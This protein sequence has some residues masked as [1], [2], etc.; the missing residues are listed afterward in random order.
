MPVV[1]GVM[2]WLSTKT[3]LMMLAC[4]SL[5]GSKLALAPLAV[6]ENTVIN[7]A[8]GNNTVPT[9]APVV[10][11]TIGN[12]SINN[13]KSQKLKVTLS[14][15]SSGTPP[16]LLVGSALNHRKALALPPP[17]AST[18]HQIMVCT[19]ITTAVLMPKPAWPTLAHFMAIGMPLLT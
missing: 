15:V 3:G 19:L 9:L 5:R 6:P 13:L 18:V 16:V 11:A 8:A 1:I 14:L 10:A 4:L 12:M 2:P 7:L 17:T